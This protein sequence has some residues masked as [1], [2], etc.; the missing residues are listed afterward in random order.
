MSAA[1]GWDID[2][3]ALGTE[4]S[5]EDRIQLCWPQDRG[6]AERIGRSLIIGDDIWTL[7]HSLLQSNEI[8]T[9]DRRARLALP[10]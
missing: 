7:S 4:V 3:E 2:V 6:D 9:L 10:G 1:R 8:D 5:D